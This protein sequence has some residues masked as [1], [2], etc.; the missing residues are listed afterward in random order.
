M[1]KNTDVFINFIIFSSRSV[2]FF[3]NIKKKLR[4]IFF[5]LKTLEYNKKEAPLNFERKA[6]KKEAPLN[7]E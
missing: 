1:K 3:L 7:F 6:Y 5:R 4:T 2:R